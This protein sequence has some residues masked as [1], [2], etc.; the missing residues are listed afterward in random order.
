M[1][2][3]LYFVYVVSS[4]DFFFLL[5]NSLCISGVDRT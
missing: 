2:F 3:L 1:G 5:L 4:A